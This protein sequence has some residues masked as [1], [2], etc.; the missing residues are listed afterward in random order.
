TASSSPLPAT[1]A[2]RASGG[3]R[4]ADLFRKETSMATWL[5][6]WLAWLLLLLT[7]VPLVA[8]DPDGKEI[9]RLV[10][11]L[12]SD[13]FKVRD[14]A[15]KRLK[16]IG[17]PALATLRKAATESGDAEIRC[18]AAALVQ[19]IHVRLEGADCASTA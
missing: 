4:R 1:R 6:H 14:A 16:D 15:T 2:P 13:K 5:P 11:Q 7:F 9:E 18:R 3:R 12:G 8:V 19:I 10:K 17:E